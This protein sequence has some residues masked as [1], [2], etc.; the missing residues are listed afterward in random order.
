MNAFDSLGA[1]FTKTRCVP[2]VFSGFFEKHFAFSA[3][4]LSENLWRGF[5]LGNLAR[6]LQGV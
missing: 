6:E 4:L 2:R 5:E 1:P 3:L